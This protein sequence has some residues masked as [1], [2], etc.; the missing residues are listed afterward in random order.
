MRLAAATGL[1]LLQLGAIAWAR[2][3]DARY[4]CWAPY[5]AISQYSLEVRVGERRL[6]TREIARRYRLPRLRERGGESVGRDNRSI[7]H[8]IDVLE[9]YQ[10]SYG[11]DESARIVLRYR[12]NGHRAGEWTWPPR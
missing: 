8:V 11:R 3:H 9:Q 1:L 6:R 7:R 12:I 10:R 4:F 2:F 5:D